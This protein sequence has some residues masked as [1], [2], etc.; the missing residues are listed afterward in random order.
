MKLF[1][2]FLCSLVLAGLTQ[3]QPVIGGL[4]IGIPIT[5][6]FT[7]VENQAYPP[8]S[9]SNYELGAYVEVR[10]PLNFSI[11]GDVLHRGYTFNSQTGSTSGSSWEFPIVAKYHLLKGPVKPY[12]EGGL[13]F[14]HLNGVEN[15]IV[16]HNTN[17]GIVLGAGVDI[18]ALVLHISPEIRYT[19]DALKNFD[20]V[21]NSN[22][23]QVAFLIGIGF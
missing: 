19:G 13:S 5:D 3:A 17:F 21:I 4:K 1:Q 18:H 8:S 2:T 20:T 12:V 22:R 14:S 10:L 16:N 23:N 6:A 11:E 15:L 7:T 9:A